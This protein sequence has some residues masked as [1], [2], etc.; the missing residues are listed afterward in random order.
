MFHFSSKVTQD[1][2]VQQILPKNLLDVVI[3]F[4]TFAH[5]VLLI[6]SVSF[7]FGFFSKWEKV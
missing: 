5:T 3:S 6:L 1:K 4:F 7:A 2:S